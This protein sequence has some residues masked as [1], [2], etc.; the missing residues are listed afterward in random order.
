MRHWLLALVGLPI[1]LQAS[2]D[3][4]A[5]NVDDYP[6]LHVF[7]AEMVKTHG[8]AEG[9]LLQWFSRARIRPDVL[10]AARKPKEALPWYRYR[11]LFVTDSRARRGERFWQAHA[12]ALARA[13]RDYGVDASTIVA[14]LGIETQYGRSAGKYP[15]MDALT[16]LMLQYPPRARFFRQELEQYL[17]LAQQLKVDP[18]ALRGSYAGAIG[19]PQFIPSSYRRYA[20]DFDGDQRVDLVNSPSDAI[21]SVANF[22]KQHGWETGAPIIAEVKVDG[23][24]VAWLEQFDHKSVMP[25]KYLIGYGV[26]PLEYSNI[27]QSAAFIRLEYE[28]GPTYHLGYNNF[29]VITRYNRSQNYAMAVYELSQ[30]IRRLHEDRARCESSC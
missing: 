4:Y 12:A 8:L 9:D 25:L 30:W 26:L 18:L 21:G 10:A 22:L 14:I 7:I 6:E 17:L 3:A 23:A 1:A 5:V 15:V 24:F 27:D 19:V 2:A 13:E 16:T 28:N 20:V 29:Y 11:Q